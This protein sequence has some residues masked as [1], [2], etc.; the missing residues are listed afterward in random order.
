MVLRV[1]RSVLR[2]DH[3]AQDAFQATF[4]ILVRRAGAVRNRGSVGS[5]LYGVALR[6]SARAR[7]SMARR[8]RHETR[9][10]AMAT[11]RSTEER[12]PL[13]LSA[14]LHEELGRLPERYRAAVVL[15]YLEGH[16]CEA[17]ASR[18]GWPVGTVKSRLSRARALLRTRLARRGLT[19]DDLA[20]TIPLLSINLSRGLIAVA[21]RSA[22]SLIAGRLTTIGVVSA[23]V[24]TLT[25]GVLRTMYWTKFKLVI[26]AVLLIMGGSAVVFSQVPSQKS[27]SR[28]GSAA[29]AGEADREAIR[30]DEL[31]VIML[32][33]A[34]VDAIPRRDAAVVNRILADDFE[35][36]DTAGNL[37]TKASYLPDLRNGA[38]GVQTIELDEIKTRLFGE[39]AV[40]T[41]RIKIAGHPTRGRMTNVYIKRQG[42]WQCVASHA[43]GI[44]GIGVVCPVAD[45]PTRN[46]GLPDFRYSL[47]RSAVRPGNLGN[48]CIDCHATPLLDIR[49][50][51]GAKN[52]GNNCI[53][54]H[55]TPVVGSTTRRPE[56]KSIVKRL[57]PVVIV[58]PQFAC[59]V[60][61]VYVRSGRTVEKG[62]PLIGL[63]SK[64]L[65]EAKTNYEGACS[66][67][68][69][70][71]KILDSKVPVATDRLIPK[72]EFIEFINDEAQSQL[73]MKLA[74]DRLQ[75]YGL[76]EE[77]IRRI[78]NE[79]GEARARFILRSRVDGQITK[80]AAEVGKDYNG[81]DVLM[82]IQPASPE[83]FQFQSSGRY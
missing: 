11:D 21:T 81:S 62:E 77:E 41:S 16:T 9:A 56:G 75:V 40:V 7:A 48:N 33:R 44:V 51:W 50:H 52:L 30:G 18:L 79:N 31:D 38:F 27:E 80:V 6:V 32:D 45:R 23:S 46:P 4:L 47:P 20:L 43:S 8:R 14:V 22:Q 36:V 37:F 72:K 59:R 70:Y 5:W 1:C 76:T 69:L 3:D 67:W 49:Q 64:E 10:A 63:F 15:C 25:E 61:G 78:P 68:M 54:C 58:Q 28:P 53:D 73:K 60:E 65:A 55:A 29:P 34:W 74:K 17:A 12:N 35:G 2:D 66:Q 82:M 57:D 83:Y 71:K 39:T 24:A 19:P 26:A 42:R 13:E